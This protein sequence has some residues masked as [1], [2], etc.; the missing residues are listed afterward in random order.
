MS[1]V[2]SEYKEKHF[3]R[4]QLYPLNIQRTR[5]PEISNLSEVQYKRLT[6]GCA[7]VFKL[8]NNKKGTKPEIRSTFPYATLHQLIAEPGVKGCKKFRRLLQQTDSYAQDPPYTAWAN[9]LADNSSLIMELKISLLPK[10]LEKIVGYIYA[11]KLN[12]QRIQ[13]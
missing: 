7:R 4:Y 8:L 2:F 1:F 13:Q 3:K 11:S 10:E 6:N 12:S 9:A 5:H